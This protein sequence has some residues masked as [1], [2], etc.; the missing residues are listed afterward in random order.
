MCCTLSV[1]SF[2]E[3]P[4]T[5]DLEIVVFGQTKEFLFQNSAEAMLGLLDITKSEDSGAENGDVQLFGN[6]LETLLVGL[7]NEILF[8]VKL[9]QIPEEI[10][11]SIK[12]PN[13][14]FRFR[15]WKIDSI[16]REIKAVT[17]HRMKIEEK[18]GRYQTH[19]VFDI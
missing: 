6:D 10:K 9:N 11:I 2:Y 8:M 4:H 1:D 15:K 3:I 17:Y 18:D 12:E 16:G 19:I 14:V 13:I 7:L 5:A